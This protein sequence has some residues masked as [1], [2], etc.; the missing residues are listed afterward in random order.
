MRSL[1]HSFFVSIAV[2]LAA[3]APPAG[4][5]PDLHSRADVS[6]LTNGSE[7]YTFST[8]DMARD[9][10][11]RYRIYLAVPRKAPPRAGHPV[12]Y[13]LDGNA[14]LDILGTRPALLEAAGD[15]AA[16]P[17]LVMIGYETPA[18]FDVKARAYDY[19]PPV[20]DKPA[21][22]DRS[23]SG[24]PAGGAETFRDF[25]AGRLKP[26]VD[27]RLR[28]QGEARLHAQGKSIDPSRQ[29]LWGHSY[30]GLFVLH[31]LLT[32]PGDFQEYY[33]ISP[34]LGWQDGWIPRQAKAPPARPPAPVA[35][36]AVSGAD[37][38]GEKRRRN[39]ARAG[40]ET[41]RPARASGEGLW[42]F[43]AQLDARDGYRARAI[44][45]KGQSHGE[46]FAVGLEAAL[47]EMV[48]ETPTDAIKE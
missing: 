44:L 39:P 13:L 3:L 20:P 1:L 9:E 11:S 38:A 5:Q 26:E 47:R 35:L 18:R 6:L 10:T 22:E 34:S 48:E 27:A 15:A 33:A 31:V 23:G 2:L 24:R 36:L 4:A 40:P 42:D 12:L 21:L 14:V 8:F 41:P 19:T 32:H 37:E 16:P 28:A 30:G 45:M 25:I 43:A 7:G 46:M 29:G 17:V